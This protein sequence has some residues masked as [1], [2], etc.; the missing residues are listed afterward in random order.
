MRY[1]P[2][3]KIHIESY[4]AGRARKHDLYINKHSVSLYYTDNL[5]GLFVRTIF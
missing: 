1:L 2:G 5:K 4:L 3:A